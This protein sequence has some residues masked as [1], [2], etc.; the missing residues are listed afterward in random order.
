[1]AGYNGSRMNEA[2]DTPI[3]SE[4]GAA[5]K[6]EAHIYPAGRGPQKKVVWIR[7]NPLKSL[8]SDE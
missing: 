3:M 2:G 5:A 7:R 6:T 8:E 1:M 4:G